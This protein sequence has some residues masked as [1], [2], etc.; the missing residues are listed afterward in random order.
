MQKSFYSTGSVYLLLQPCKSHLRD[1]KNRVMR[2]PTVLHQREQKKKAGAPH[3]FACVSSL[4]TG[5][6]RNTWLA[7]LC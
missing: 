4:S 1:Y 5:H 3:W 7:D 2:F 6:I